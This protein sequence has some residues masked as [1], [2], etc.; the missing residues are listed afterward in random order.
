[1]RYMDL[2]P[3]DSALLALADNKLNEAARWDEDALSSIFKNLEELNLDLGDAG[4]SPDELDAIL[5]PPDYEAKEGEELN[6]DDFSDFEH[7][8][9]RCSFEWSDT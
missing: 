9:P 4:W 8:C 2:D 1:M 5:R 6:V 7:K 3:A